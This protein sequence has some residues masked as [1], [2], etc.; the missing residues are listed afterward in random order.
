[1]AVKDKVLAALEQA[2]GDDAD[3]QNPG[4]TERDTANLDFAQQ[5]TCGNHQCEREY[6]VGYP[7]TDK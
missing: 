1:M 4:D 7:A 3:E 6:G 5:N 2:R